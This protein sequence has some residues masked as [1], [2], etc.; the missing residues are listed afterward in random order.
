[1]LYPK[2]PPAHSYD[3]IFTDYGLGTFCAVSRSF[4]ISQTTGWG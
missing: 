3:K 4:T 1:M 2:L